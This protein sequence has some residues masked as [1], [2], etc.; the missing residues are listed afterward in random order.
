MIHAFRD[1]ADALRG[2]LVQAT[3]LRQLLEERPVAPTPEPPDLSAVT[4]R[5]DQIELSAAKWQAEAE[6][7]ILKA[8]SQFQNAR[9]AEE[10]ARS[11]QKRL[12]DDSEGS[13]ESEELSRAYQRY[14]Q[15]VDAETRE[16]NG[17]PGVRESVEIQPRKA[18]ALRAKF[19]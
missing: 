15:D 4:E 3:A 16:G 8:D 6:A 12:D 10:R 13:L 2:L 5:V 14:L 19:G 17:L 11:K 7:L 9:N 18:L 1:G